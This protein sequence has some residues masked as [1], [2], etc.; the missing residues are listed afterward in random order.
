MSEE[1]GGDVRGREWESAEEV[2]PD[3]ALEVGV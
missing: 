3:I 1:E 2:G